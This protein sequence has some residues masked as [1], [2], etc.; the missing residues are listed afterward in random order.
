MYI[1]N[2]EIEGTKGSCKKKM[3]YYTY[4]LLESQRGLNDDRV[5]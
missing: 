2:E 3:F 1:F 4:K 5:W